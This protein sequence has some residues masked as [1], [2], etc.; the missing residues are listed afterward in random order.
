MGNPRTFVAFV[1]CLPA[2]MLEAAPAERADDASLREMF[3]RDY[4]QALKTLE[5]RLSNAKGVV[6]RSEVRGNKAR[7]I[8]S[9]RTL[10]FECK[11]PY[12]ARVVSDGETTVTKS[13]VKTSTHIG[14]APC[15][16]RDY[17]FELS[18]EGAN[19]DW[20]V[21]SFDSDPTAKSRM[22]NIVMYPF[23]YKYLNAP[24]SLVG[25]R[26]SSLLSEERFSVRAVSRVRDGDKQMLRVEFDRRP[27]AKGREGFHGWFVVSPDEAW[28]V[29]SFEYMDELKNSGRGT[30]EYGAVQRGVP[31]PKRVVHDQRGRAANLEA[32]YDFEEISLVDV[33]DRDFTLAAFGLPELAQSSRA[34]ARGPA[35]WLFVLSFLAAA[36]AMVLKM[37]SSRIQKKK[38]L[39]GV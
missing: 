4:P 19:N 23:L 34:S 25:W 27:D 16:N 20:S 38:A 32:T 18:R 7:T 21:S 13:D 29:R 39:S 36:V 37:A 12:M 8:V 3:L 5:S 10:T 28:V 17:S 24:F 33:P 31:V 35:P 14:S 2:L 1:L 9:S 30:V 22:E 11:L 26:L 15:Y 6:K